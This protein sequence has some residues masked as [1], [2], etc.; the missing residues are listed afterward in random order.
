MN[1]S[2]HDIGSLFFSSSLT[3]IDIHV[4]ACLGGS[5]EP[6]HSDNRLPGTMYMRSICRQLLEFY[7]YYNLGQLEIE[8][9]WTDGFNV[10]IHL[11]N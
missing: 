2:H 9:I 7:V 6:E 1:V 11:L 4:S 8:L 3:S 5:C 10:W